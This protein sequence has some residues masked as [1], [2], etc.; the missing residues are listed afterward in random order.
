MV[1]SNRK[2]S[3][4]SIL[5]RKIEEKIEKEFTDVKGS[6]YCRIV[7]IKFVDSEPIT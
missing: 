2:K 3:D 4:H 6:N 5:T 1:K 7:Y